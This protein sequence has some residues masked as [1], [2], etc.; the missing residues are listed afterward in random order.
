VMEPGFILAQAHRVGV[1]LA[2]PHHRAVG[3]EQA[4]V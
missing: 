3:E 4:V 1:G 2:Q